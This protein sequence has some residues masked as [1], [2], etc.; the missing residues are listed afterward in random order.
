MSTKNE[1]L[2]NAQ[3]NKL[4]PIKIHYPHTLLHVEGGKYLVEVE[5]EV[6]AIFE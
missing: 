6:P 2:L 3:I 1:K 5:V 4:Y